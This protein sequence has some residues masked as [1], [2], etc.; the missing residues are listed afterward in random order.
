MN[1]NIVVV[2]K[3]LNLL[4]L[5][6]IMLCVTTLEIPF[7]LV[8][9]KLTYE[10]KSLRGV[11]P[12]LLAFLLIGSS[13]VFFALDDLFRMAMVDSNRSLAMVF[14]TWAG[15]L[16]AVSLLMDIAIF[17]TLMTIKSLYQQISPS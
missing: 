13:I 10:M 3:S 15:L 9:I 12:V 2:S 6:I 1:I 11:Y 4:I 5:L 8:G 14:D 17:G 16:L 7:S